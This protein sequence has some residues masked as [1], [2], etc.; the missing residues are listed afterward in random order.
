MNQVK[1]A[2]KIEFCI[3][4]GKHDGDDIN[5]KVLD[6]ATSCGDALAKFASVSDYP[7]VEF[8]IETHWSDDNVTRV[9]VFGGPEEALG[10][11]GIWRLTHIVFSTIDEI[12][13]HD[14]A[15]NRTA[16]QAALNGVEAFIADTHNAVHHRAEAVRIV[17]RDGLSIYST[18]HRDM[19]D[20]ELVE[21]YLAEHN[22]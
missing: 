7:V 4:A 20:D 6:T 3:A 1:K 2:I 21:S 16:D 10:S 5:W 17:E 11:D 18:A 15:G 14:W 22:V 8:H 19:E 12:R 9:P 13:A